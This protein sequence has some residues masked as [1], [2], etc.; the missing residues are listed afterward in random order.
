M[1]MAE[2]Q[3]PEQQHYKIKRISFLGRQNVPIFVQ[4]ENGPCPLLAICNVLSLRNRLDIPENTTS[5]S[6]ARLMSL[7]AERI[8]DANP[9]EGGTPVD[10]PGEALHSCC[11]IFSDSD[12]ADAGRRL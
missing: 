9:A 2:Q 11:L 3:P 6:C 5:M 8:L 12:P 7:V 1:Q 10:R 4:N